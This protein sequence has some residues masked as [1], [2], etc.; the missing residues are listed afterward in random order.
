[1]VNCQYKKGLSFAIFLPSQLSLRVHLACIAVRQS[2][3]E[4]I[5]GAQGEK[6]RERGGDR[7][8]ER[9][10]LGKK[11]PPFDNCAFI[12]HTRT[13]LLNSREASFLPF[14][15]FFEPGFSDRLRVHDLHCFA[16]NS[17]ARSSSVSESDSNHTC[18]ILLVVFV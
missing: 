15:L 18:V 8:G 13:Q 4:R 6:E 5:R 9:E 17:L 2:E 16:F 3:K 10:A 7:E 1:M 11:N 14:I 12:P